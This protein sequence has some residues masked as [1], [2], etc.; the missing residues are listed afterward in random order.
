MALEEL[1]TVAE[2]HFGVD[3]EQVAL[4]TSDTVAG[5]VTAIDAARL[6]AAAGVR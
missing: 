6:D 2:E 3:L 4:S 5:L 1:R